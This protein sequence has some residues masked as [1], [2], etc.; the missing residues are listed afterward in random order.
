MKWK[1]LHMPKGIVKEKGDSKYGRFVIEPFERGWGITVGNALRRVLLSSLQGA[2]IVSVKF[3][4]VSH[5]FST[6][7][8]VKEDVA[9]IILNIKQLRVKLLSDEDATL[10]LD[11]SGEGEVRAEHI[12]PN[13]DVQI[14]NPELHLATLS[15]NGSITLEMRVSDG[16]GY[17]VSDELKR[18]DDPIGV[19]PI[20]ANFSPVTK[21]AYEVSDTRVG[22]RTD[23]NRLEMEVWTDG[24]ID[25]ED[26]MAYGA[27]LLVDHLEMFINFEGD[28]E[29]AE[30]VVKDEEKE[31][32]RQL[33]KMRVDELEL[34]VRSSNCLRC[35]NIH[36]IADLVRN[37]ESE[38]LKYKNFGRK[39]LIELNEVLS[40]MGLSFGMDVDYYLGDE[41]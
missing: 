26:S 16:R 38:M 40:N 11:I 27:K 35:A 5:E 34:S 21:V 9:E 22:Q 31:R 14:L 33:L 39:S 10:R 28:L 41:K 19:I 13:P 3:E 18:E 29:A 6:L 7:E 4:G 8:G 2:A 15:K 1:A 30:E 25:P 23:F 24:S 32:I 12:E 20:D 17:V 37:Q 36:T